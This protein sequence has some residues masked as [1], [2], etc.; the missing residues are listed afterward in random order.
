W[1]RLGSDG[2]WVAP[3]AA[4]G[5]DIAPLRPANCGFDVAP[6]APG[7]DGWSDHLRER[8]AGAPIKAVAMTF[9]DDGREHRQLGEFVLTRT[10]IE[11]SL[12]YAFS[13]RL[14][15]AIAAQGRA[16]P[17]VDLLP[18]RTH[19]QVLAEVRRPRGAR[20][21]AT[22]LKSRLNLQGAKAALLH[23]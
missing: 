4:R 13:A 1:P 3:L 16:V 18:Q 17:R 19:E 10:G 12:V 11:G 20:S 6:T 2:A 8:H 21:L 23:E 15:D 7:R 5:V 9:A 14:R 22:H